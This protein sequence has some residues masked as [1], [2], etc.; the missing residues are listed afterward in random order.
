MLPNERPE[1]NPFFPL[2]M[3]KLPPNTHNLINIEAGK[4]KVP[5]LRN[6]A[7]TAPYMHNGVFEELETVVI[8]YN[9]YILTNIESQ[10]NPETGERWGDPEVPPGAADLDLLSDGQP[11]SPMQVDLLVTFLELLTDRRYEHLLEDRQ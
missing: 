10:T 5:T 4:F 6:V 7:V 1:L 8:F 9:K 11:V 2:I 3:D